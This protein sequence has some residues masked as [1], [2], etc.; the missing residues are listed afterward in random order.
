MSKLIR[1]YI[2]QR[3]SNSQYLYTWINNNWI[4]LEYWKKYYDFG[5]IF[6]YC[7]LKV[8]KE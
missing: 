7:H 6:Q 1:Y 5:H 3:V 4:S 8:N 2:I